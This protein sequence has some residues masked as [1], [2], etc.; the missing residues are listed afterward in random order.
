VPESVPPAS[1]EKVEVKAAAVTEAKSNF[2]GKWKLVRS[3]GEGE[4]F[5]VDCGMGWAMRRAAAAMSYGVGELFQTI[6]IDDL[7]ISSTN[8]GGS[9]GGRTTIMTLD[10][11]AST[12]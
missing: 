1:Q 11:K 3:E 7:K 2:N 12:T 10:G 9:G 4:A 5:L 6:Q 8:E